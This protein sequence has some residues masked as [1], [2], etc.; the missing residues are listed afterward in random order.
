MQ[1]GLNTPMPLMYWKFNGCNRFNCYNNIDEKCL[2]FKQ[3]L[4]L[5]FF[6]YENLLVGQFSHSQL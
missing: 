1:K 6:I 2:F 5:R 3:R 4:N